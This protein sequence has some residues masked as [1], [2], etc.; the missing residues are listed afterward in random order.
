[1]KN[2]N[3]F[4]LIELVVVIVI[5]GILAAFAVPRFINVTRD[6]RV[7]SV[8]ACGGGIR[9]A[10]SLA[11]AQ[12]LV[13]GN[14]AA[15]T[16]T[17]DGTAVDCA[18]G[19]GIPAGTAGGIGTALQTVDGFNV[20]YAD[21]TAVTFQPTNGGSATCQAT[22]NGTTGVVGVVTTGCGG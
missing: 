11:R 18:A 21:P 19:T 10:V 3:G 4:T 2:Q 1:M 12:Y 17:M 9:A 13:T 16:V 6:A 5:L 14:L 20:S 15:T 8:N 22:Y 7:A